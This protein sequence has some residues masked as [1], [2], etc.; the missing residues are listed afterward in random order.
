MRKRVKILLM[1]LSITFVFSLAGCAPQ[2]EKT[3]EPGIIKPD[4]R[5][6][7]SYDQGGLY[8]GITFTVD[9]YQ[10]LIQASAKADSS[11][12]YALGNARYNFNYANTYKDADGEEKTVAKKTEAQNFDSLRVST[13]VEDNDIL[14]PEWHACVNMK[15]SAQ[16]A[17]LLLPEAGKGTVAIEFNLDAGE[18]QYVHYVIVDYDV[19]D[20]KIEYRK[21]KERADFDGRGGNPQSEFVLENVPQRNLYYS[22]EMNAGDGS[23]KAISWFG[24]DGAIDVHFVLTVNSFSGYFDS[25][26]P[27]TDLYIGFGYRNTFYYL[28]ENGVIF[29]SYGSL[30]LI[31]RETDEEGNIISEKSRSA[32]EFLTSDKRNQCRVKPQESVKIYAR[33]GVVKEEDFIGDNGEIVFRFE[34]A[35]PEFWEE[36]KFYEVP[37]NHNE[38]VMHYKKKD[39]KIFIGPSQPG[40]GG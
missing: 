9:F 40:F 14:S 22:Q 30:K 10:D 27:L 39:G 11:L 15:S 21:I 4:L 3:D 2:E 18:R 28:D 1:I 23:Y 17:S 29:P 16:V 19:I 20:D 38:I 7:S 12:A 34:A 35:Q 31:S 37:K 25:A 13:P 6:V 26:S 24:D 33:R 32:I 5:V 36:T 8:D